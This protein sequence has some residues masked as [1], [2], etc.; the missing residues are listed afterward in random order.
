VELPSNTA[1]LVID[2]QEGM[3]LP[4]RG[5]RNNP[6][7]EENIARLL[8]AWRAA[9]WPIIHVKHNS[10]WETSPFHASHRG[11][12]VQA[13][14]QP[15][16]GEPLIE[17]DVNC[18]FVGTDLESRLRSA[19]ITTLVI[20]GFVTNH[21]VDATARMAGDLQFDTYVVSDATG[22][23]DRVGPDGQTYEA[24]TIHAVT[25]A[26]LNGEFATVVDTDAV[27]SAFEALTRA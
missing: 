10:R 15:L 16:P 7:A 17:K 12:D 20:V 6:H 13:F 14:A 5:P 19:G 2:V 1:L 3:R 18:A 22:T 24:A 26:T 8:D 27:L 4:S 23:F 11:N 9:G 21:C 25:L